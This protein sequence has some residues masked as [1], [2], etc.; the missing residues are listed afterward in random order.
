[1]S[2]KFRLIL[3]RIQAPNVAMFVWISLFFSC[4]RTRAASPVPDVARHDADVAALPDANDQSPV[5]VSHTCP[6]GARE[7]R[8]SVR[9]DGTVWFRELMVDGGWVGVPVGHHTSEDAVALLHS[10]E[11]TGLRRVRPDSY[12]PG[13]VHCIFAIA[14]VLPRRGYELYPCTGSPRV[15]HEVEES[16]ALFQNYIR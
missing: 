13:A 8:T 6:F 14:A 1:M 12:E 16:L 5:V 7:I 10:I 3:S 2:S 9:E 15:P 4:A 11:S